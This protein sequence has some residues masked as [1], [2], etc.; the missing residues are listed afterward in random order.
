MSKTNR[1]RRFQLEVPETVFG[2]DPDILRPINCWPDRDAYK[3]KCKSLA[4]Q[5][6]TNFKR[7]EDGVPRDVIE[8]GGPD[9]SF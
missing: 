1:M 6:A 3:T 4:E 5:F 8:K 7:Y 9:L 2:V